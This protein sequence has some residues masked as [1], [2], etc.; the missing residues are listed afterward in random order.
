MIG[1]LPIGSGQTISQPA[2]VAVHATEQLR[3]TPASR[4]LEIGTGSGYQARFSPRLA[5]DVYS[6][7]RIEPA[8]QRRNPS[9]WRDWDWQGACSLVATG[10]TGGPRRRLSTAVIVSAATAIIPL[11]SRRN[12]GPSGRMILPLGGPDG[13]QVL[14]FSKKRRAG[15]VDRTNLW[16]VRFVPMISPQCQ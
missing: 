8:G 12:W 16:P 6:I 15:G 11:C 10:P 4:V 2:V 3:L 5:R 14:F 13:P 1:P 7:E 9:A